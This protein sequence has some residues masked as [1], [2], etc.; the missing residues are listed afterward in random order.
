MTPGTITVETESD[1]LI[2]HALTDEAADMAAL[3]EMGNRVCALER[4]ERIRR[5]DY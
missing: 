3:E 2:V 5:E 1:H 4:P